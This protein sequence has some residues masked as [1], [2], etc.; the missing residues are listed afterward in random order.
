ML[1]ICWDNGKKGNYYLLIG[2]T[3]GLYWVSIGI[4]EN[5]METTSW[6]LRF[7]GGDA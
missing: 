7:R 1:G 4:M 2:Y 3:F 5:K 6:G